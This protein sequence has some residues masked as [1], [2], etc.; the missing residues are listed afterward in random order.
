M[1]SLSS[2]STFAAA[3]RLKAYMNEEVGA[4][5][6]KIMLGNVAFL[7]PDNPDKAVRIVKDRKGIDIE[8]LAT[9]LETALGTPV[10]WIRRISLETLRS[11]PSWMD[12]KE[13]FD[14]EG[15]ELGK[16]I[17]EL[18]L[19]KYEGLLGKPQLATLSEIVMGD[20]AD[21]HGSE[22]PTIT[23]GD[24]GVD[25]LDASGS[26]ALLRDV[27]GDALQWICMLYL[28]MGDGKS[29]NDCFLDLLN[30]AKSGCLPLCRH[31]T[32]DDIFYVLVK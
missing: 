1:S 3:P 15:I 14:V 8:A 25:E 22:W 18:L 9:T 21:H 27:V 17:A 13:F 4:Q 12:A 26:P 30:V 31:K 7:F 6:A 5:D 23:L 29:K 2:V 28:S 19:N 24:D 20:Q 10:K 16:S 32:R 11:C